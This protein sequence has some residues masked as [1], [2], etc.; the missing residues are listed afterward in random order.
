MAGK[1]NNIILEYEIK[2]SPSRIW[3]QEVGFQTT[4]NN[5]NNEDFLRDYYDNFCITRLVSLLTL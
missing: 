2:S 1:L 3:E 5:R 4:L